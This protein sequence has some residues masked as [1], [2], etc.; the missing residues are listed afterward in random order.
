MGKSKIWTMMAL[1]SHAYLDIQLIDQEDQAWLQV[2]EVEE[3]Q[4]RRKC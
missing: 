1:V 2:L 4:D 3:E